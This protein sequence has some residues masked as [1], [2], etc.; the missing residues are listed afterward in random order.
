MLFRLLVREGMVVYDVGANNG[1]YSLIAAPRV[2]GSGS[3]PTFEQEPYNSE[4]L[5]KNLLLNDFNNVIANQ[6]AV[7]DGTDT[8]RKLF[9]HQGE[10]RGNYPSRISTEEK[11]Q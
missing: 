5:Q 4:R 10:K 2:R 11:K 7:S 1:L 3:V 6:I 8:I 9:N